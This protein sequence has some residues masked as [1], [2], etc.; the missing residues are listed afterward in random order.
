MELISMEALVI[1]KDDVGESDRFITLLNKDRGKIK[2]LIKGIRKSKNREIYATEPL[3]VGEYKLR[4]KGE[5]YI[6]NSFSLIKPY[7]KIKENFFKLELSLYLLKLVEKI[8]YE[9]INCKKLYSTSLKALDYIENTRD[10][11]KILI[12][13]SFFMYKIIEYEG[14]KPKILGKTYFNYEKGYIDDSGVGIKL[15]AN[16]YKYIEF[17]NFVD[18]DAVN[19]LK[20]SDIEI[21]K[22]INILENYLNRHLHLELNIINYF[23]EEK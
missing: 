12:M 15:E 22:T 13:F 2:V 8:T 9:N 23:R 6:N 21:L 4:K 10:K 19:E 14:L 18:I 11:N 7:L 5:T 3:V 1:G 20:F 17:L 16:Q